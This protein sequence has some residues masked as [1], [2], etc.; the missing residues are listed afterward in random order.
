MKILGINASPRG[1]KSQTLKLVRSVLDGAKSVGAETELIDICKL[2]IKFC[3]ACQVCFRTGKCVQQDDFQAL[4]DKILAADGMI[5]GS[6]NYFR[7]VTA[8]LKTLIDRMADAVHC[9]LFAG[10]YSCS[11]AT[12]GGLKYGEVTDY[13]NGLLMT[14][15][16]FVTGGVG[17]SMA[18]GPQI[19]EKTE[20][21]AF[22]LG[23]A[24]AEDIKI[25]RDYIEQRE[26]LEENRAYFKKLVEMH[27][28]EWEHEY[29]Y[30]NRL[31]WT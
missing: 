11:V 27:K 8:Q 19:M 23:K 12:A 10:K 3:N 21:A 18:H 1:E 2:D 31:N 4:Y 7:S 25:K 24:L 17:A 22:D 6:P 5:W 14:F 28:V 9:Q 20:K 26:T 13:L 15:G 16:S 30:W 29:E